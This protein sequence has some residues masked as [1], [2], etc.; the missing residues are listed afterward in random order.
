MSMGARVGVCFGNKRRGRGACCV[1][2]PSWSV[3][4]AAC[5]SPTSCRMQYHRRARSSLPGSEWVRASPLGHGRRKSV[6]VIPYASHAGGCV[7]GWGPDGGRVCVL[8]DR[9]VMRGVSPRHP[10]K[11]IVSFVLPPFV[12][13]CVCCRSTV[14]TGQLHPL[15]GFHVRP[16]DHVFC[17]ESPDPRR[18]H[19]I[20]ISE[21]ASRLDAF[22]GYPSRT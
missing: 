13:W 12:G 18:G 10:S 6:I 9:S 7:V 19:G 5:Y 8:K 20:L 3:G 21:Q 11:V 2:P 4:A 17:M 22:S 14:S 1:P 16:I 15:R